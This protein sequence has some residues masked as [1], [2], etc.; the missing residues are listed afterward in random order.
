VGAAEIA[1][2]S[3][4]TNELAAG[5]VTAAKI[6]VGEV[7]ATHIASG[8]VGSSEI[9]AGA[10]IAGKLGPDAVDSANIV[11]AAV[12]STEIATGAVVSGKLAANAV[13]SGAINDL[14]VTNAK[15]AAGAVT[16]PKVSSPLTLPGGLVGTRRDFAS[17]GGTVLATDDA[18]TCSAGT[19]TRT[20][21]L[22]AVIDGK[23][24]MFVKRDGGTGD[25]RVN[26]SGG[27]TLLDPDLGTVTGISL[28]QAGASAILLGGTSQW[29]VVSRRT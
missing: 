7:N 26:A 14:A 5:A 9:A 8:A 20:F 2:G 16:G 28:T 25:V 10:V 22:P 19:S 12:G 13:T 3:I 17:V 6:G 21:T 11:N 15:I 18:I 1:D 27:D 23:V 4:G 29:F 24:L